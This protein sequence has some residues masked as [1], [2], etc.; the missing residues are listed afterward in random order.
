MFCRD[1]VHW[2]RAGYYT[3]GRE[4]EGIGECRMTRSS[5]GE[6]MHPESL[7]VAQDK[8]SYSAT[9]QPHKCGLPSLHRCAGS[10]ARRHSRTS[11]EGLNLKASWPKHPSAFG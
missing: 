5:N 7:A 9:P 1:C 4:H 8:E 10:H 3:I 2:D 11:L 6:P